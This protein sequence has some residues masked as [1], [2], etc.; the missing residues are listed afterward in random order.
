M[1]VKIKVASE[2]SGPVTVMTGLR[3]VNTLS[4]ILFNVILEIVIRETNSNNRRV[5]R[6]SN[7]NILAYAIDISILGDT[8]EEE[9][10]R[11]C[12]KLITMARK[13]GLEI[14]DEKRST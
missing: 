5:L 10:K 13:I 1:N 3:Q 4:P 8:V 11:V 7:I 2:V 6:N 14:N 9:V 12:K